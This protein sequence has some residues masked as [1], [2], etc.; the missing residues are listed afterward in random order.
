MLMLRTIT[1]ILVVMFISMITFIMVARETME[2]KGRGRITM[3]AMSMFM[4][5]TTTA[6]TMVM[7]VSRIRQELYHC[8]RVYT[9]VH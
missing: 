5:R 1:T 3:R 9:G 4:M 2:R 7:T 8:I 6:V